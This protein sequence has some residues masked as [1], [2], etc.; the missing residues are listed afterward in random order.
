M[1]DVASGVTSLVD[2]EDAAKGPFAFDVATAAVG[3]CFD[4]VDDATCDVS[5][6]PPP[7]LPKLDVLEALLLSYADARGH[8][9]HKEAAVFKSLMLANALAC[10]L[11]RFHQFHVVDKGAPAAAK[12][13]YREMHAICLALADPTVGGRIDVV[14]RRAVRP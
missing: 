8:F 9:A 2:W 3:G 7:A 4:V 14:A 13:S 1:F 11:Y 12:R 10:A 6:F 5:V